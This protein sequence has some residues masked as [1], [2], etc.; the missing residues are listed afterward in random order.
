MSAVDFSGV[1]WRKSNRS[2]DGNGNNCVA[3]AWTGDSARVGYRDSKD[4]NRATLVF[5]AAA[6]AEFVMAVRRGELG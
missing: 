1:R 4:P 6:H 3:V 2:G 5:P